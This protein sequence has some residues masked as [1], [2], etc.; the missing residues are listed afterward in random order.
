MNESVAP[1]EKRNWLSELNKNLDFQEDFVVK[2]K[3]SDPNNTAT[4][5]NRS[6]I[7]SQANII[8]DELAKECENATQMKDKIQNLYQD[9]H[10]KESKNTEDELKEA[11]CGYLLLSGKLE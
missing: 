6:E 3:N 11:S 10:L 8:V 5:N 1:L 9:L 7:I 4:Y 2:S